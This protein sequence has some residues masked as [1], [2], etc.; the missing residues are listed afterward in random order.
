MPGAVAA[1]LL[2]WCCVPEIRHLKCA[3]LVVGPRRISDLV[4]RLCRYS[5]LGL[6]LA[7]TSQEAWGQELI[8]D[9]ARIARE[10]PFLRNLRG[11]GGDPQTSVGR[12]ASLDIRRGRA[13]T[14]PLSRFVRLGKPK[15]D[16]E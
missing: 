9:A 12:V 8:G 3:A 13:S 5:A 16:P 10:T 2:S 4:R 14:V 11:A 15:A 1:A 6:A 7:L